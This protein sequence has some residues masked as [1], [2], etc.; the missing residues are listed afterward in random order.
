MQRRKMRI[1]SERVLA[2]E[3]MYSNC[4]TKNLIELPKDSEPAGLLLE[5]QKVLIEYE[6]DKLYYSINKVKKGDFDYC[7]LMFFI[8]ET[9]KGKVK[10]AEIAVSL[11]RDSEIALTYINECSITKVGSMVYVDIWKKILN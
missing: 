8:K 5:S 1:K 4:L 9:N 7:R 11:I 3:G 2:I 10:N 6:K